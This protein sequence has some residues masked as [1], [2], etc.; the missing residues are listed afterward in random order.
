M[1]VFAVHLDQ[2]CAKIGAHPGEQLAQPVDCRSVEHAA[3]V[4]RH[5]Y[6]MGM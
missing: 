2:V 5:K 6:Q 4:L 1:I 3:A